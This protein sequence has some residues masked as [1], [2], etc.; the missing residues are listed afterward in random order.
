MERRDFLSAASLLA[1]LGCIPHQLLG[2][3]L[4]KPTGSGDPLK[5]VLLPAMPPL[6][7]KGSMDIRVWVRSGMTNGLFSSVECAVAPKVMGPAP[8]L[9]KA[10][11]ELMFVLEGTASVM[12]EEEVVEIGAGGWHLRP[13][14][15]RH[16]FWNASDQPL[17]FV[18]M[19]FNQPFE[20]FL[21][22]VFFEYTPEKGYP[23]GSKTRDMVMNG[24]NE[25]FGLVYAPTAGQEREAIQKKYGL[26]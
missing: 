21:E 4:V 20:E 16:T 24:L 26:K 7:H 23:Y 2:G 3:T 8:H 25:Q 18:D 13:R 22:K 15:L 10:L 12:V 14:N 9:H 19:Y 17:R 11:D 5:P 1:G 6:D